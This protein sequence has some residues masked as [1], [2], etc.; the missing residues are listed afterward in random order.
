[1]AKSKTSDWN[2][3]PIGNI[4]TH[5]Q[6]PVVFDDMTQY[7]TITVKRRHG[8]LEAREN[9]FGHEIK[10][11]KQFRLHPRAFILSRVQCWHAAFAIVPDD[12]SENMIASQNYDQFII[13][14]TVDERFFWWLS[15]SPRFIQSVRDST[16]GVVIEK[17]VFNRAAWLQKTV[18]LP[19]LEVQR[20]IVERVEALADRIA[21]AQS[22]REE[23]DIA[24]ETIAF[25]TARKT[26]QNLGVE[27][28]E[29]GELVDHTRNGIQ[30]GPFGAQ[31]GSGD[32][33]E[34]GHP[35]I[36]IGTVQFSGLETNKLKFISEEKAN[37]L[38]RFVA[39]E[40]DIL[41]ARM[42]TVGRCCVVPKEADGWI[43]NYHLIRVALD[44]TKAEPRYIH[45]LIR[46]SEDIEAKLGDKKRGATREGVNSK[47]VAL[48]P[49]RVPPLEEQ[50]RI[51]AYLDSVQ[52]RLA[53]LRQLQSE[54]QEELDALL[55]SVLDRAFKGEL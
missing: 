2:E 27:T 22:L 44:R 21:K 4:L 7:T 30:T 52:A 36:T 19:P 10:T 34:S 43:Y 55:P 14:S 37:Q 13:S 5:I 15:H 42:G 29:L 20:R 17:V 26:F 6:E 47:I 39:K 46:A 3:I 54:T 33:I 38:A 9:L 51:V 35:V 28:I 31:L 41:F 18:P 45:W 49:C 23:A 11:K 1:M 12:I 24:T 40:G 32:F 53:S 50:R 48:L 8:G 16:S 25:T